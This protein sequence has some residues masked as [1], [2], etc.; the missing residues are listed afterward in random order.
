[1]DASQTRRVVRRAGDP[2]QARIRVERRSLFG[3]S[4]P[5]I[6]R[7]CWR[8]SGGP[9]GARAGCGGAP[10]RIAGPRRVG[11]SRPVLQD[12][13]DDEDDEHDDV[14]H[15]GCSFLSGLSGALGDGRSATRRPACSRGEDWTPAEPGPHESRQPRDERP[16]RVHDPAPEL[17]HAVGLADPRV[18]AVRRHAVASAP[19]P[20]THPVRVGPSTRST[21]AARPRPVARSVT[22]ATTIVSA[23]PRPVRGC[24]RTLQTQRRA[25]S[26]GVAREGIVLIASSGPRGNPVRREPPHPQTP[27]H[28]HKAKAFLEGCSSN[29]FEGAVGRS[30]SPAPAWRR[31]PPTAKHRTGRGAAQECW[32]AAAGAS[33]GQGGRPAADRAAGL[34][35]GSPRDVCVCARQPSG[36]ASGDAPAGDRLHARRG[37]RLVPLPRRSRSRPRP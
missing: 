11:S 35:S 17:A 20:S 8:W 26:T 37:H 31:G 29:T 33:R 1:M 5:T 14:K 32:P 27:S 21:T 23:P 18:A 28:E 9:G 10:A 12:D 7:P 36:T 24:R 4:R 15:G 30:V 2:G 16:T 34:V 13:E 22:P 19:A 6:P 3:E 25:S